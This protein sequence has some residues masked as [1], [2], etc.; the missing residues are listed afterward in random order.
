MSLVSEGFLRFCKHEP[1][2]DELLEL[3]LYDLSIDTI[4][5]KDYN[6]YIKQVLEIKWKTS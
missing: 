2:V 3:N 4:S 5:I 1:Y 6:E